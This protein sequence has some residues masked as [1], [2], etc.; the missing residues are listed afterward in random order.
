MRTEVIV[1]TYNQP[2]WLRLSLKAISKQDFRDFEICIADDGS[3]PETQQVIDEARREYGLPIRHVWQENRGYGKSSILNKSIASSEAEYLVL[4]DGDC[5]PRRDWLRQHVHNARPGCYRTGSVLRLN[6]TV[7]H[8]IR[9]EDIESG[10]CFDPRWIAAHGMK[11]SIRHRLKMADF[12]ATAGAILNNVSL[13]KATWNGCHSS[14]WRKDL[15]SVN[16]FDERFGYGGEDKEFGERLTNC[17]VQRCHVR[18]TA[19]LLH[20]DHPRSY[21]TNSSIAFGRAEIRNT[22]ATGKKWTDY[23][24]KREP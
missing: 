13:V 18:Y 9:P 15:L 7:S 1:N 11:L 17:G 23:G 24:I 12:G 14:G 5:L 22:R 6:H 16:G 21:A 19:V 2:A 3:G 20:L 4:T 10:C 8:Q